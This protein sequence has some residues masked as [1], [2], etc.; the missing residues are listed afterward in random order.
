MHIDTFFPLNE[1]KNATLSELDIK[2]EPFNKDFQNCLSDDT[3]PIDTSISSENVELEFKQESEDFEDSEDF[4]LKELQ[5]EKNRQKKIKNNLISEN[6]SIFLYA[7]SCPNCKKSFNSSII[8]KKTMH[9]KS[10]CN[11]K[12]RWVEER[13]LSIMIED[14]KYK[15]KTVMERHKHD[16]ID[17]DSSD[18]VT[19][20]LET[21][22][23]YEY[24]SI[25]KLNAD[26]KKDMKV[27]NEED[28]LEYNHK[29]KLETEKIKVEADD[30]V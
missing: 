14:L 2:Q 20:D 24:F 6:S 10:C 27:K 7:K 23:I 1:I 19:K 15:F 13:E 11:S 3:M 18:E 21:K 30:I 4:E 28:F 17:Y 8:K 29:K 5:R 25:E 9:F 22:K 26:N 12:K 16:H